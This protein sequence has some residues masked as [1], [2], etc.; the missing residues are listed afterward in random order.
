VQCACSTSLVAVHT[1]CQAL[2]NEECDLALAG[3]VSIQADADQ[4]YRYVPGSVV[5]PDG[6][7]RAFDAAAQGSIFGSGVGLV[8]LK[9]LADALADRDTIRAVILGSA[10]TNDGSLK[11][12]FTAPGVDGRRLSSARRWPCPASTRR[13]RLPEAHGTGTVSAI[14]I[15]TGRDPRLPR[16]H[17]PARGCAIGSVKGFG[18]LERGRRPWADEDR[19]VAGA[20]RDPA[21]SPLQANRGS[22]LLRPGLRQPSSAPGGGRPLTRRA[23][24]VNSSAPAAPTPT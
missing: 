19:A 17:G 10:V 14:R 1:A 4:G 11:V 16:V 8:V 15:E 21:H 9:R 18:H 13:D 5:S 6:H 12:G 2:L 3:G 22:I 7:C 20:R 23:G 24:P